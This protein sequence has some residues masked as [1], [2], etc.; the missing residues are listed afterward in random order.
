[1]R[2][3]IMGAI[4]AIASTSAFATAANDYVGN[5]SNVVQRQLV[6]VSGDNLKC[7]LHSNGRGY[8]PYEWSEVKLVTSIFPQPIFAHTVATKYSDTDLGSAETLCNLVAQV[9]AQAN[10]DGY[11]AAQVRVKAEVKLSPRYGG[12]CERDLLEEV[13]ISFANGLI[14]KAA[15]GRTLSGGTFQRTRCVG[16][17]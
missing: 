8:I 6:L 2:R 10:A 4:I 3:K 7:D 13:T 12:G 9:K 16:Q 17:F 14:L 11:I 5:L 15:E 1:M